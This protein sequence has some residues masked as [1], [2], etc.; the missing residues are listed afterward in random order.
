MSNKLAQ[1]DKQIIPVVLA[2]TIG[3]GAFLYTTSVPFAFASNWHPA[4]FNLD[5]HHLLAQ[6]N[7]CV[8]QGTHCFNSGNNQATIHL[9]HGWFN[10]IDLGQS[11]AQLNDCSGGSTCVNSGSNNANINVGN[12]HG[13]SNPNYFKIDQSLAQENRCSGGSTCVNSGSNNA[14]ISI[15]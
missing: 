9:S 14:N 6:I 15:N 4:H 1:R 8:D 7:Q 3:F 5:L 2:L 12:Y 10:H 13:S 11:L